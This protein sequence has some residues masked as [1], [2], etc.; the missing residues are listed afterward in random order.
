MF[1]GRESEKFQVTPE[2]E[3]LER[4][5]A[6]L[7]IVPVQ[8]DRDRL[9]FDAGRA[10]ERAEREGATTLRVAGIPRWIWPTATGLMTA[11]CLVLAAMLVWRDEAAFVA[12]QEAKP[13]FGKAQGGPAAVERAFERPAAQA[14]REV[15]GLAIRPMPTMWGSRPDGGYLEKRYVALTLGVGELRSDD[16]NDSSLAPHGSTG[17]ATVRNL[18]EE[19]VPPPARRAHTRS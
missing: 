17:P 7:D 16:E 2:L 1:G 14:V 12:Q 13:P 10:A 9:M 18:L 19:L 11:A 6:G 5:L 4:Q 15:E 3:A 8:L